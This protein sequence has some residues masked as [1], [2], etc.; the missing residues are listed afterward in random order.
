MSRQAAAKA[1]ATADALEAFLRRRPAVPGR[2]AD[3]AP[4]AAPAAMSPATP[5]ERIAA[6]VAAKSVAAAA[7][8]AGEGASGSLPSPTVPRTLAQQR[9]RNTPVGRRRPGGR[10]ARHRRWGPRRA[11]AP[12]ASRLA[13][14]PAHRHR[15]PGGTRG[16]PG[17]GGRRRD[18]PLAARPGAHRRGRVSPAGGAAATAAAQPQPGRRPHP[19]RP[20]ARRRGT[21]ARPGAGPGRPQP[22][23]PVRP[24]RAAAGAGGHVAARPGRSGRAGLAVD[25]L[26]HHRRSAP[27][28]GRARRGR[29]PPPGRRAGSLWSPSSSGRP[30]GRRG[31]PWRRS[32]RGFRGCASTYSPAMTRPGDRRRGPGGRAGRRRARA[33]RLGGSA[34][35]R[36]DQHRA[37]AVGRRHHRAAR[38]AAG[39]G[40]GE[41]DRSGAAVDRGADRAVRRRPER[42]PG[43]SGGTPDRSLGRLDGAGGQPHRTLV[44]PGAAGRSG[45]GTR[46]RG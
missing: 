20:A 27:R 26:G 12:G 25:A 5:T 24:A 33:D 8:R 39:H 36:A 22:G 11:A 1:A 16:V 38:L 35:R 45:G 30:T 32:G 6:V 23:L 37:G 2:P 34:P 10:C 29:G 7:D 17:R 9:R 40:A 19:R 13:V 43:R 31:G 21:A 15:I 46:R 41:E 14:P 4:V 18:H 44:A 28:D 42:R 3:V